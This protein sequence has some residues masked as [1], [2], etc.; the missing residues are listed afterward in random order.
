MAG[1][2]SRQPTFTAAILPRASESIKY[3]PI[4]PLLPTPRLTPWIFHI[5][6]NN[7]GFWWHLCVMNSVMLLMHIVHLASEVVDNLNIDVC[8]SYY[9][10]CMRV[11]RWWV[12]YIP[13]ESAHTNSGQNFHTKTL[14]VNYCAGIT[15]SE[16]TTK[17][18]MANSIIFSVIVKYTVCLVENIHIP[19][20]C[21]C[22]ETVLALLPED[23]LTISFVTPTCHH[24]HSIIDTLGMYSHYSYKE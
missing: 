19:A 13:N 8:Y 24:P 16:R 12:S 23:K 1:L 20:T 11:L 3:W 18:L 4:P 9:C 17:S 22:T 14:T 21:V 2:S 15:D 5:P 10:L 6:P 7:T